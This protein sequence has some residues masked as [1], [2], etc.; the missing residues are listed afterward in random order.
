MVYSNKLVAVIKVNGNII[1]EDKDIVRLPFGTE[2][3][4]LLKNLSIQRVLVGV[5]IDG[6]DTLSNDK[7]IINAN[8]QHE[9]FGFM[10]AAKIT[11]RFKFIQKTEKIVEHRGDKIDDGFINISF[12]FEQPLISYITTYTPTY[13]PTYYPTTWTET[14]GSAGSCNTS[15]DVYNSSINSVGVSGE[16][17]LRG[18]AGISG[19]PGTSGRRGV[20][21]NIGPIGIDS[22]TKLTNNIQQDEGI[23][24]KGSQT[25]IQYQKGFIGNLNPEKHNI[26]LRLKGYTDQLKTVVTPV[27]NNTKLICDTCG[28]KC[29][30]SMNFCPDCGTS[31]I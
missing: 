2:Y 19:A 6:K 16:I 27:Y 14:Y 31:L 4:I 7:I 24:V 20:T 28:R 5:S 15:F 12:Q 17:G 22:E 11:N 3:S 25:N 10:K 30:S 21:G 8:S 9:L 26:I 18:P 29:K 13:Y 23:T 1:R